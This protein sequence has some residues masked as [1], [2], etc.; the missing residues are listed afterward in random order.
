MIIE[1]VREY[2]LTC[3]ALSGKKININCL[4]TAMRSL[5]LDNVQAESIIKKYCDGSALKQAVFA[6]GIRDAYDENLAEN[7]YVSELIQ[8]VETWIFNQNILKNLPD[9]SLDGLA[10]RSIEVS[11]GGCLYDT[12]MGSGRWQMEFRLVYRQNAV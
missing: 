12:S 10:S 11:K 5:T 4:G 1:A 8:T 7:L 6:L 2:L 9:L 3:P